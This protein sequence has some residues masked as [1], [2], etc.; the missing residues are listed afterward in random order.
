MTL[1]MLLVSIDSPGSA[2]DAVLQIIKT[3]NHVYMFIFE[4]E[5]P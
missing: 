5:V 3:L 4:S 1:V 2:F